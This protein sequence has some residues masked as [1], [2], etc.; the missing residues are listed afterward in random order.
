MEHL[1]LVAKREWGRSWAQGIGQNIFK[2][3]VG[4]AFPVTLHWFLHVTKIPL[5]SW[6]TLFPLVFS[7]FPLLQAI[8]LH[9]LSE[10]TVLKRQGNLFF[11]LLLD[12]DRVRKNLILW[13]LCVHRSFKIMTPGLITVF[14]NCWGFCQFAT[15]KMTADRE[16]GRVWDRAVQLLPEVP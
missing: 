7:S 6:P 14:L 13:G 4:M 16:P 10:D 3:H 12:L 9:G 1:Q 2:Y 15:K 8:Y 11:T 5:S